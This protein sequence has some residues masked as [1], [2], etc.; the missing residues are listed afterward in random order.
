MIISSD[1][2]TQ[3]AEILSA[4][5]DGRISEEIIDI[6]VRRIL[7]FK[8]A[9]GIINDTSIKNDILTLQYHGGSNEPEDTV[10]WSYEIDLNA[11]KTTEYCSSTGL[12]IDEEL[13]KKYG[14]DKKITRSLSEDEFNNIMQILNQM[15]LIIIIQQHLM[16]V[17]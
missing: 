13:I 11:K 16:M 12:L 4:I 2:A 6:A 8:Y 5:K 17:Q 14:Y 7:A 15:Q 1:F 10:K 9:Y 3:K